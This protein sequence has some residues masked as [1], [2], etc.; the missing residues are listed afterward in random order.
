MVS[1]VNTTMASD[2]N[3]HALFQTPK[4]YFLWLECFLSARNTPI[5]SVL[6]RI[7]A[8]GEIDFAGG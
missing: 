7:L 8:F 1:S 4:L 5:G 6:S 2:D 3:Y